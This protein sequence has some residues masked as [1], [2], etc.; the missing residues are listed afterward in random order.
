MESAVNEGGDGLE[1][2]DLISVEFDD[3]EGS[4]EV[5]FNSSH[6]RSIF[7]LEDTDTSVVGLELE[8]VED[9][10]KVGNDA[11]ADADADVDVDVD[12]LVVDVLVVDELSVG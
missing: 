2:D 12:V 6:K 8:M 11:D 7:D 1:D 3:L 5:E 10:V 9:S 4:V